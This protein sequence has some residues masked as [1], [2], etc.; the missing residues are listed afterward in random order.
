[1]TAAKLRQP[2]RL[3]DLKR[4]LRQAA[5]ARRDHAKL[6]ASCPTLGY[7][8]AAMCDAG[9]QLL[10]VEY[11]LRGAERAEREARRIGQ[12]PLPGL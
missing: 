7:N 2:D 5:N 1:M 8:P 6:C 9:Y 10:R 12:Q 11:Q 4:K 3:A